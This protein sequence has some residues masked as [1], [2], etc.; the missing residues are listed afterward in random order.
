MAGIDDELIVPNMIIDLNMLKTPE[1]ICKT[2]S[3]MA[4]QRGNWGK[5][6]NPEELTPWIK[7]IEALLTTQQQELLD[8]VIVALPA[9]TIKAKHKDYNQ[10]ITDVNLAIKKIREEL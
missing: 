3:L 8:R 5:F 10:A 6:V 7:A 2:L 1:D 9:K 4:H